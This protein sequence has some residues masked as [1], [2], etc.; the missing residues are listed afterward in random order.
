ME[1]VNDLLAFGDEAEAGK[2]WRELG[3]VPMEMERWDQ[4][5]EKLQ[6]VGLKQQQIAETRLVQESTKVFQLENELKSVRRT[7]KETEN[8]CE[9][10]KS[11]LTTGKR[12]Q[13]P[14]EVIVLRMQIKALEEGIAVRD[15][16]IEDLTNEVALTK[17]EEQRLSQIVQNLQ[18][19]AR[20]TPGNRGNEGSSTE[21][22]LNLMQ[23][24]QE[25]TAENEVLAR[26]MENQGRLKAIIDQQSSR[27]A[28]LQASP[29]TPSPSTAHQDVSDL[30]TSLSLEQSVRVQATSQLQET[31]EALQASHAQETLKLTK[32]LAGSEAL[33]MQANMRIQDLE[34]QLA[35]FLEKIT[36]KERE[37]C[38]LEETNEELEGQK[39]SISAEYERVCREISAEKA[40]KSDISDE[41]REIKEALDK[42]NRELEAT[43]SELQTVRSQMA[44]IRAKNSDLETE[45]QTNQLNFDL[46]LAQKLS[47][48]AEIRRNFESDKR[49]LEEKIAKL[50][51]ERSELAE[52][53]MSLQH[54][55]EELRIDLETARKKAEVLQEDNIRLQSIQESLQF[56]SKT[57]YENC[58][59]ELNSLE[60]RYE[61]LMR[62]KKEL[63]REVNEL[64]EGEGELEET[65]RALNELQR[66]HSN[67]GSVEMR[68]RREG[69]K[70]RE[71][72]EEEK[73][74]LQR[75]L[76]DTQ[77]RLSYIFNLFRVRE[78]ELIALRATHPKAHHP[79]SKPQTPRRGST[80]AL[81]PKSS[82][83]LAL[84][85][86]ICSQDLTITEL[87][88]R[89]ITQMTQST[90]AISPAIEGGERVELVIVEWVNGLP[91]WVRSR[92]RGDKLEELVEKHANFTGISSVLAEISHI[93]AS[94]TN[95]NPLFDTVKAADLLDKFD[96]GNGPIDSAVSLSLLIHNEELQREL[97]HKSEQL[98]EQNAYFQQET[99]EIEGQ[100]KELWTIQR[101]HESEK[102]ALQLRNSLLAISQRLEDFYRSES[103]LKEKLS[104]SE[105]QKT[106]IFALKSALDKSQ[107]RL[108]GLESRVQ[109][110]RT[111]ENQKETYES[112]VADLRSKIGRLEGE[113]EVFRG[114]WERGAAQL[115]TELLDFGGET[116]K[117]DKESPERTLVAIIGAF[118]AVR[119][120]INQ[121]ISEL[122]RRLASIASDRDSD[123]LEKSLLLKARDQARSEADKLRAEARDLKFQLDRTT[124]DLKNARNRP[125]SDSNRTK[126]ATQTAE[127]DKIREELISVKSALA[128]AEVRVKSLESDNS[129]LNSEITLLKST[130]NTHFQDLI[131]DLQTKSELI[132]RLVGDNENTK[133]HYHRKELALQELLSEKEE[134]LQRLEAVQV[135]T[136]SWSFRRRSSKTQEN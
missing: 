72:V 46:Q 79:I 113:F 112:V 48:T 107:T 30:Q 108:K 94:I 116:V 66:L 20:N 52:S 59:S 77:S 132:E 10:L 47:E 70:D 119:G 75:E 26:K 12:S 7:L 118:K 50:S 82:E 89:M 98:M 76:K 68:V 1:E 28:E 49:L 21:E 24:I 101:W 81:D 124:E 92:M 18:F 96:R 78:I 133:Q 16:D 69:E 110:V 105:A 14:A 36:E 84:Q 15:K 129:A 88:Q 100:E 67:C 120:G 31:L 4:V 111:L 32:Q 121:R 27:I 127:N 106:E 62:E 41:L 33:A 11:A 123:S 34:E 37:I 5:Y 13:D 51:K 126:S 135:T 57:Q 61:E 25:L 60:G 136:A 122:E 80:P 65:Q 93:L 63:E 42:E 40:Q 87:Q 103:D 97:I 9:M 17:A 99:R 6:Q 45:I 130:Q 109:A 134:A 8:E 71:Q 104:E 3:F 39:A 114:A 55:R 83:I 58:K 64:K 102:E 53:Q 19:D 125:A 54:Q 117:V 73:N 91:E 86:R 128:T 23:K 2:L 35:E 115:N 22:S 44:E 38:G 74:R 95:P 43:R 131:R 85:N 29:P 90:R 56:S